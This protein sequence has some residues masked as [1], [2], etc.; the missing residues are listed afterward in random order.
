[1]QLKERTVFCE[2]IED[3]MDTN[4]IVRIIN[5]KDNEIKDGRSCT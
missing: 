2:P 3:E 4:F 1:M 5:A